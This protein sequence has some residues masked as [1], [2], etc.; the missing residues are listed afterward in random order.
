MPPITAVNVSA[1][2][3]Q[4]ASGLDDVVRAALER[5]GIPPDR[6]ELELTEFVLLE[7]TQRHREAFD[8][9]R[10][11]GVKLAIDDFGTGFSSI[12]YLRIFR[13]ARLKLDRKFIDGV[14]SNADDAA[15]V[16]AAAGLANA[17]GIELV[18]E[19]V[20]TEDQRAFLLSVGCQ[21]AQ[22]FRYGAPMPAA[23]VSVLLKN[24]L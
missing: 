8:K 23:D 16:R 2:Q 12:D 10:E 17:L 3:F 22:G 15:I 14:A 5:H 13:V 1:A 20:C 6:L 24:G 4:F 21:Y 18:A 19:G 11:I 7:A 9:L